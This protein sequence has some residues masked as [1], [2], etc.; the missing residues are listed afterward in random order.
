MPHEFRFALRLLFK[1][2]AFTGLVLLTLALGIGANVAVFS[3]VDQVLLRPL[4]LHEPDRLVRV[5]ERHRVSANLTGATFHDF[6]ERVTSLSHV[7]AYRV[8]GRNLTDI[9]QS[10][11]PEQVDTAYVSED[12]FAV[13]G[14]RPKIGTT[15][16][17]EM[18]SVDA[19]PAV[20]LSDGI[21]R[22]MFNA[23]PAIVNQRVLLHGKPA[24][25]VGI[26]PPGFSFPENAQVWAPLT[27]DAA[28]AQ[29]RRAHLFTTVGRLRPGIS[30]EM[31]K[32]EMNTVS[33]AIETDSHGVDPGM[34]LQL[35]SLQSSMVGDVRTA[36][37]VLLWA[38]GFVLLI[39]CANAANM[40][41]AKAVSQQK[42]IAT[43]IALGATRMHI[44]RQ[45][46]CESLLLAVA[47][48][49][50]GF[51]LGF[52]A[53]RLM[54]I[55]YPGVVPRLEG[56]VLDW[57]LIVF[58]TLVATCS[59]MLAGLIPALQTFRVNPSEALGGSSRGTETRSRNRLRSA[60]LVTET[61]LALVLLAAAGLL[62]RSFLRVQQVN[63]GYDATN[64]A[65]A[66]VTLPDASYP[67][68]EQRRQFVDTALRNLSS[69]PGVRSVAAAGVLPLRPA[70][71]TD[72]ELAGMPTDPDHE[73]SAFVFT[74]TPDY[75]RTLS[76]PLLAGRSFSEQDTASSPVVV[77]INQA[78]VNQYYNDENPV[79]RM[80]T[81]KD[82]G[83]PL[84]AQI[85]GIV[86]DTRQSSLEAM[87]KP[88]VYFS[89]TQFPQ[90]TLVTY[91]LV[92]TETKP[93]SILANI[94]DRIRVADKRMP[95][96]VSTMETIVG[97]SLAR[98]RFLLM[99]LGS[100]AGI[101]LGLATLG[102][103]GVV[104][105][106]VSTRTRE[107]GIRV[108]VGA[109]RQQILR[110]VVLQGLR[111]AGAGVAIGLIL[112][113]LVTRAIT[114]L[115]YGVGASDPLTFVCIAGLL[116]MVATLASLAP[117]I[118]AMRVRPVEALRY[119]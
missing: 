71:E 13:A 63:P 94:R 29:N 14:E 96:T 6:R 55:A 86:G 79:G 41:L 3:V 113:V 51:L 7:F 59:A 66:P 116:L 16:S 35:N 49:V 92:K 85:V 107:F 24:I 109:Q 114:S 75:F 50:L 67:T 81:M 69:I 76:I 72:F 100:F 15:F 118:Q 17:P 30:A 105:Y 82:W 47:G 56:P 39:A 68:F 54:S 110:M 1:K 93:G 70:P 83:D 18:F 46:L 10:A 88:A 2:P 45:T 108:A 5:Q 74:A 89:F 64:V 112:G 20:L 99:L 101:A 52:W 33:A 57:R 104:S 115:L 80:I 48:G 21:W 36:L 32:A 8:F 97:Q 87:P 103:Y 11:F 40:L 34:S 25:V 37:L 102:M 65:V 19:E 43:R 38:V 84:P 27:A 111:I 98:R 26:M 62:I 28:F 22:K 42:E 77:V 58:A 78:M 119:E 23:D 106:S 9:R 60:V 73:P 31:A 61:A 91:L 53:V 12:F 90:G 44:I 117:A 4:P 95:V